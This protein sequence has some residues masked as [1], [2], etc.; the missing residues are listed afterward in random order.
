VSGALAAQALAGL[1]LQALAVCRMRNTE[2]ASCP[3]S[4]PA[5]TALHRRK[6]PGTQRQAEAGA[7][8][9]PVSERYRS[10]AATASLLLVQQLT[11]RCNAGTALSATAR[12]S[13]TRG[14][15]TQLSGT[16]SHAAHPSCSASALSTLQA[17]VNPCMPGVHSVAAAPRLRRRGSAEQ[18]GCTAANCPAIHN[19]LHRRSRVS[20]K[21]CR[22]FKHDRSA[23]WHDCTAKPDTKSVCSTMTG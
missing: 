3:A 10:A 19:I 20:C 15:Y 5:R 9:T 22:V 23:T 14:L 6:Q 18:M 11:T 13:F 21:W 2:L 17:H 7:A 12:C 16:A 1:G 4:C 8:A